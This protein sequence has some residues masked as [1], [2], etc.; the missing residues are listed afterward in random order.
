MKQFLLQLAEDLKNRASWHSDATLK[1]LA[2]MC[3]QKAAELPDETEALPLG[4]NENNEQAPEEDGTGGDH[5][6]KK[7]DNP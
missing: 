6:T 4:E 7:P 1:D 5:P 3:E 2:L